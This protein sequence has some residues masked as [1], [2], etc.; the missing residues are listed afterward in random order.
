M[1]HCRIFSCGAPSAETAAVLPDV[2]AAFASI[3]CPAGHA[4]CRAAVRRTRMN[5]TNLTHSTW[6]C[7]TWARVHQH[8]SV[9][10]CSL[11]CI[12][13]HGR[14]MFLEVCGRKSG[15][16]EGTEQKQGGYQV[17]IVGR[18]EMV[19]PCGF[20]L[21]RCAVRDS[22][23]EH[24]LTRVV[25]SVCLTSDPPSKRKDRPFCFFLSCLGMIWYLNIS[26]HGR[27]CCFSSAAARPLALPPF[28]HAY[29]YAVFSYL[30]H[31]IFLFQT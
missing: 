15:R 5:R 4:L 3:R 1:Y 23:A 13:R 10:G 29:H 11:V 18:N 31:H 26:S 27:A 2:A 19:V 14:L 9:R 24:R 20:V 16:L 17:D 8:S 6:A 28:A 7:E 22:A 21:G 30:A 12:S 25:M